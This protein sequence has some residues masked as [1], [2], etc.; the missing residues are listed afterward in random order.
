M[1]DVRLQRTRETLPNG[2]QF[3]YTVMN[4]PV[5]STRFSL[6]DHALAVATFAQVEER[7]ADCG[8]WRAMRRRVYEVLFGEGQL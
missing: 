3:G 5:I 7:L 1:P 2:Y 8:L 6:Q 4:L